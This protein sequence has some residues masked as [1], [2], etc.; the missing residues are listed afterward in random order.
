MVTDEPRGALGRRPV[1]EDDAVCEELIGV[2]PVETGCRACSF[3]RVRT[4]VLREEAEWFPDRVLDPAGFRPLGVSPKLIVLNVEAGPV[5]VSVIEV[6]QN[7]GEAGVLRWH[8]RP[9]STKRSFACRR[10][11]R[12]R[13]DAEDAQVATVARAKRTDEATWLHSGEFD[14]AELA[15]KAGRKQQGSTTL[16]LP[17]VAPVMTPFPKDVDQIV[18]APAA[19]CF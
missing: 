15:G 6:P 5:V 4:A 7:H 18:G 17:H 19:V 1:V 14:V 13:V 9:Q 16:G 2:H 12:V 8:K 10:A 11:A 3:V